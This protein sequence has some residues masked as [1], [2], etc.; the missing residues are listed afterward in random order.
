[1]ASGGSRLDPG[2]F[3]WGSTPTEPGHRNA[4]RPDLVAREVAHGATV[5]LE[6][7]HKTRRSVGEYCHG[8]SHELAAFVSASAFLT[9]P[10]GQGLA[11]HF[12]LYDAFIVQCEGSKRWQLFT[13]VVDLPVEADYFKGVDAYEG[14]KARIDGAADLELTMHAGD[15]LF[16]PRGWIHNCFATDEPSLHVALAITTKTRLWA[17]RR[18]VEMA[19]E[20]LDLRADLPH[21]GFEKPVSAA[22]VLASIAD[23]ASWAEENLDR[24]TARL[25]NALTEGMSPPAIDGVSVGL[26]LRS[27]TVRAARSTRATGTSATTLPRPS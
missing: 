2:R 3:T 5:I 8:L 1:M 7:L 18:I 22:E 4:V 15:V 11:H 19:S 13:P 9:P 14:L 6:S 27:T 21:D 17:M 23:L 12:D 26:A 24:I 16:L 20:T 25:G 10:D